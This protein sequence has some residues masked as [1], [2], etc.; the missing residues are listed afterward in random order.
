MIRI[1]C[2]AKA[3]LHAHEAHPCACSWHCLSLSVAIYIY[4]VYYLKTYWIDDARC[5]V[6]MNAGW[7]VCT[8]RTHRQRHN[9]RGSGE[10]TNI[11]IVMC[12]TATPYPYI[13]TKCLACTQRYTNVRR[14]RA[15]TQGTNIHKISQSVSLMPKAYISR[16]HQAT[17]VSCS[18]SIRLVRHTHALVH[19]VGDI[20]VRFWFL[21]TNISYIFAVGCEMLY[22]EYRCCVTTM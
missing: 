21:K 1:L 13:P 20:S 9:E 12:I 4:V 3:P 5:T 17:W 2:E 8:L 15:N 11:Y 10:G 19:I 7:F 14:A 16:G 6:D 18:L 22:I